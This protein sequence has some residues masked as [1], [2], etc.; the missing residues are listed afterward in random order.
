ML[1]PMLSMYFFSSKNKFQNPSNLT[2]SNVMRFSCPFLVVSAVFFA[3]AAEAIPLKIDVSAKAAILLNAETG[4][5]LYEKNAHQLMYPASITKIST[6]M[7]AIEKK[8]HD[9]DV[10]VI[11]SADA[12]TAVHPQVRRAAGS[13]HPPY[14]LEFGGS[15]MGIKVGE[16]LSFKALLYGLMLSSGNDAANVIAEHV[17]GSVGNFVKE[18]DAYMKSKGCLHTAFYAPH[19]LPHPE[20]KTTAYDLALLAKEG[21]KMPL[22]REIV[23]TA[24]YT[25]PITNL[26]PQSL[27]HQ[28]NALVKPGSKFYYPK[29][30]GIKTGYT[31]QAGYTLIG[32]AEDETRKLV[33]VLLGCENL[34]QRYRDAITLFEAA[35]N[36]K[37][38][39]RTLFSKDF[40]LFST[41]IPGGKTPLQAALPND[42]IVAYYPSEA[43]TL[44]S[45]VHWEEKELP[46]RQED[47][48]GEVRIFSEQGRIVAR[49]PLY[50]MSGVDPTLRCVL[51]LRYKA[52]KTVLSAHRSIPLSFLGAA[53]LGGAFVL[54]GRRKKVKE[55]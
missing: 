45:K 46:I 42:L 3:A 33:G 39:T 8:G 23:K 49:Q 14:R 43:E 2:K 12:V 35:F 29:A 27:M 41:Q 24:V 16:V 36:E 15:S 52:L 19:G 1:L 10:Q 26:Q 11:A 31:N 20:H 37:K 21:M 30:A 13:K 6:A 48:V 5:V 47:V 22:F 18:L 50:A 9:L 51:G 4:A 40:D 28:H 25:R 34:D 44:H 53:L 55:R 38:I 7:Y 54:H 17:S 32:A